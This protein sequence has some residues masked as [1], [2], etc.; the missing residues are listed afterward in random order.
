MPEKLDLFSN[1]IIAFS[2]AL[3][4][5]HCIYVPNAKWVSVR[6]ADIIFCRRNAEIC[7]VYKDIRRGD[8]VLDHGCIFDKTGQGI[9]YKLESGDSYI[10]MMS[11]SWKAFLKELECRQTMVCRLEKNTVKSR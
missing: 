5:Y 8:W 11:D 3:T 9:G 10:A 4:D 7:G 2:Q 6:S 1:E